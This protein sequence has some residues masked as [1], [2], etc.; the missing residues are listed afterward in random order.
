MSIRLQLAN[1]HTRQ[2]ER[3]TEP[4]RLMASIMK[5]AR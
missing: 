4:D 1:S 2:F 5:L 3:D